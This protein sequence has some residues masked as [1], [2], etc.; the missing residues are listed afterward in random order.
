MFDL[1]KRSWKATRR[2]FFSHPFQT[3]TTQARN[4]HVKVNLE[5][6]EICLVWN[7]KCHVEAYFCL[8]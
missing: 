8:L 5:A 6:Y 7:I 1:G 2:L 4:E 3:S